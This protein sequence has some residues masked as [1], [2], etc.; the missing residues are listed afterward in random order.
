MSG[1]NARQNVIQGCKVGMSLT[2]GTNGKS[3]L[4]V[5]NTN[6][7]TP[8]GDVVDTAEAETSSTTSYGAHNSPTRRHGRKGAEVPL[9]FFKQKGLFS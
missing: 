8:L 2:G 6:D 7:K 5:Q 4:E 3:L 9:E 1:G